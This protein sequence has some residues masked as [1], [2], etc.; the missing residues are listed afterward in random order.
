[1]RHNKKPFILIILAIYFA[2]NYTTMSIE[3][4]INLYEEAPDQEA[5]RENFEAQFRTTDQVA[6]GVGS[7]DEK[8]YQQEN[9]RQEALDFASTE[10]SGLVEKAMEEKGEFSV[11]TKNLRIRGAYEDYGKKFQGIFLHIHLKEQK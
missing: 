7:Y 1:M 10:L 2:C 8:V 5:A 3:T 4:P 9:F 6:F 11:E